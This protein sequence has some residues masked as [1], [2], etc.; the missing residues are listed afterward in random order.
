MEAV[1][2]VEGIGYEHIGNLAAAEIIDGGVPVRLIAP[3]GIG[4]FVKR[5]AV[6]A[7]GAILVGREMGWHP[8]DQ[9][10][11]PGP[12]SAIDEA[13]EAGGIAEAPRGGEEPDGL[14]A[15]GGIKGMLA[16]RQQLEM[17]ELHVEGIG[18]QAIGELVIGEEPAVLAALPGAQ[19]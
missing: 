12:M 3:A 6:E 19:M 2:P 8:V 4:I 18:D 16:N 13:G 1:E 10:A 15:P 14:I 9:Q 17:G 11:E 5:L 7:G